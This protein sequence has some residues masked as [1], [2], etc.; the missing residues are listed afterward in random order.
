MSTNRMMLAVMFTAVDEYTADK[1]Y[2]SFLS[3]K[4]CRVAR[5]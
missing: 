4:N 2:T 1:Y 3:K 5:K